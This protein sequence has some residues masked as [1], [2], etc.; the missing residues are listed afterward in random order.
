M[1]LDVIIGAITQR[2]IAACHQDRYEHYGQLSGRRTENVARMNMAL[3][4][5]YKSLQKAV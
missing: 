4:R 2:Y 5:D 1:V 3:V